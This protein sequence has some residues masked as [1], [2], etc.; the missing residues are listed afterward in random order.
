MKLY[1][2]HRRDCRHNMDLC[3][4]FLNKMAQTGF[5]LV[6]IKTGGRFYFE[7][8]PLSKDY[9]YYA[10][11]SIRGLFGSKQLELLNAELRRFCRVTEPVRQATRLSVYRIEPDSNKEKTYLNRMAKA[12]GMEKFDY[13]EYVRK[14][15]VE[16]NVILKRNKTLMACIIY[17]LAIF[18]GVAGA[19][20]HIWW[21]CAVATAALI[22]AVIMS[23][24]ACHLKGLSLSDKQI[25]VRE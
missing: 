3:D 9:R 13:D 4:M 14:I 12:R 19:I 6:R 25:L 10:F 2:V 8:D 1:Y 16:R 15:S 21:V 24:E 22:L 18:L 7:Y 5:K 23:V 20:E 17:I 11:E